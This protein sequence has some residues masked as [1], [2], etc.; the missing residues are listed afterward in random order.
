MHLCFLKLGAMR[1]KIG[2]RIIE[3]IQITFRLFMTFCQPDK[4]FAK[5]RPGLANVPQSGVG[6]SEAT[7]LAE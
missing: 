5:Q 4:G 2:F 7:D 1:P 3:K 6:R